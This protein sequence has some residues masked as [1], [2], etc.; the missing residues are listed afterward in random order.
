MSTRGGLLA[1][2]ESAGALEAAVGALHALGYR[3]VETF[4]PLDLRVEARPGA[5]RS[6]LGPWVFGGG[7]VGA[8]LGYGIQWY[9]DVRAFPVAVG[10]RPLHP[11][12]AFIPATFEATVLCAAL[13]AFIG[14]LVTIRLPELWH[15]VFE[16][17]G[18][19]RAS[20]DRFWVQIGR[21]DPLFE[22]ERT[23]ADLASLGA[24]RVVPV[25]EA[26]A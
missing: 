24:L 7:V 22:R 23:M 2:L 6:R 5:G 20:A 15:P 13:A 21:D 19:E 10:G 3:A 16:V 26:P 1:E 4:A 8:V 18:F 11:I 17:D 12:P 9:A 25:P 14:V